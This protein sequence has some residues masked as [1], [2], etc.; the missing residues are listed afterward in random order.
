MDRGLEEHSTIFYFSGSLNGPLIVHGLTE[1]AT[2]GCGCNPTENAS[3]MSEYNS[4][5]GA[6]TSSN[7]IQ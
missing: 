2:A 6:T 4:I 1:D 3:A 5:V 7:L